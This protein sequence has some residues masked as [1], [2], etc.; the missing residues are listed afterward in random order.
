MRAL[1]ASAAVHL[2]VVLLVCYAASRSLLVPT[3]GH[4]APRATVTAAPYMYGASSFAPA[5]PRRQAPGRP[6]RRGETNPAGSAWA[7]G[8]AVLLLGAASV[9]RT[10]GAPQMKLEG[11]VADRP[12]ASD[13]LPPPRLPEASPSG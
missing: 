4:A 7:A 8:L 10:R 13:A 9:R 5:E 2:L 3:A 12:R 6:L 11:D 1:L